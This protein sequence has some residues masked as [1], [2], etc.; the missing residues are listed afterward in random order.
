[1]LV[2]GGNDGENLFGDV[3][4][5]DAATLTWYKLE[6]G[7]A[8]LRPRAGHSLCSI[9]NQYAV[10][11]GGSRGWS[12]ETFSDVLALDLECMQWVRVNTSG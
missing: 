8:K 6:V 3:W 4:R 11:F 7:G 2:V 12:T 10:L 5:L 1:M 9:S